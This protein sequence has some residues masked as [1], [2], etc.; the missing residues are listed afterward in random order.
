MSAARPTL[1]RLLAATAAAMGAL[2]VASW[3]VGIVVPA[4][5][6]EVVQTRWGFLAPLSYVVT[7][8]CMGLGGALAG[9]RF[10]IV[11]IGLTLAVWIATLAVLAGIAGAASDV[12]YPLGFLLRTNALSAL[13]S[14]A[15]AALG[16]WLGA[17]WRARR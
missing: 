11:A 2:L 3:L 10:L 12:A 16:T 6:Q 17:V 5:W 15:A 8:V 7:A 4:H 14:V 13:L 1:R 9:H